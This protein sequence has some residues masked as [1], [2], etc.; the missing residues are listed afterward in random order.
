[1]KVIS[2]IFALVFLCAALPALAE[3][4]W[5]RDWTVVTMTLDGSWGIGTD[6]YLNVATAAAVR[7]CKAKSKGS[8]DCG[9]KI[10]TIKKGWVLGMLCGDYRILATGNDRDEVEAAVREREFD[11][12]MHYVPDLPACRQVLVVE[13]VQAATASE[14]QAPIERPPAH[15]ARIV[16]SSRE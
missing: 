6:Q 8:D 3:E 2:S 10:A 14:A 15:A 7:D 9:A 1:M 11:L 12:K 4:D 13:P 5:E 16:P